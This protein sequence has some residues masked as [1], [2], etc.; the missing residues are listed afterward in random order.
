MRQRGTP[1]PPVVGPLAAPDV[2]LV[3][4]SLLAEEAREA[5]RG[6][7][8]AGRVLPLALADREQQRDAAAQPLEVVAVQVAHVVHRVVEVRRLAALAPAHDRDV[9]DAALADGE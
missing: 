6:V 2:E 1:R 7:E 3:A 9:I 4:D 8:R 5:A